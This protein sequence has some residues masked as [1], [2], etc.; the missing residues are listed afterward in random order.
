MIDQLWRRLWPGR[1]PPSEN[2]TLLALAI[3]VGLTTGGGVL[4]FKH[5][6]AFFEEI[7]RQPL[8]HALGDTLGRWAIVPVLALGGLIVG[9]VKQRFIGVERHHGVAGIM[10]AT[11]LAGGRL[12]YGRMPMKALLASFSIGAGASVGPE[13]PSV[14]IGANLG[15]MFGQRLHLSDERVRLLVAAGVAS[16]IAAA[17]RAPIAGVFFALEVIL[18]DLSTSA[19]GVVVLASVVASVLTQALE[20][21]G[22]E[23]GIQNYTLG[24]PQQIPLYVL[25]AVLVAPVSAAYIRLLYWQHDFWHER[26]LPAPVKTMLAGAIVGLIA[27][28]LPEIMGT[29]RETM[30]RL[31]NADSDDFTLTVLAALVVAKM[32]ATTISLGGGFV[33]GMFAPSL[34]VG[35]AFGSLYGHIV[36]SLLP[37]PVAANPAAYAVTGMAATMT[38]VIRAPITTVLLLFEL[39]NDY[40]LIL[41]V[42]LVVAVSLLVVERIAP[43]GIY[44][45]GLARKGIRLSYGRDTDLMQ[46]IMAGDA[47]TPA[48]AYLIQASL[49]AERLEAEFRK[50]NTHGLIVV[51]AEGDLFGIV[52]IQDLARALGNGGLEGLSAGDICTRD[53]LTVTPETP[54][55]DAL[56]LIGQRDVG[57]LPVVDARNPRKVVGMLRRHDILRSYDMALQRKLEALRRGRQVRL[58]TFTRQEVVELRVQP[59]APVANRQIQEIDWPDGTI[60]AAI[61][62]RGETITPHGSTV[63]RDG[64]L[65]TIVTGPEHVE[66]LRQ[67]AAAPEKV[68]R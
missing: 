45:L 1:W 11:A 48:A 57:R 65:L 3:A 18:A 46:T 34:F 66:A 32:V 55:S 64:D 42:M 58:A 43:D 13:D 31:L 29:G 6:F 25:L 26:R 23:L 62:R 38:G 50:R 2:F 51:D 7:Y 54:I 24:G 5:G 67:L 59:H 41:P 33:G 39:T 60:V 30:N 27:A 10:E 14:Q 53:V 28:F 16:G 8:L 40:N 49:P 20:A 4:L 52:T 22:P 68:A 63:V 56:R 36:T 35:A 17:F 12:R 9:A 21:G 19:F 15:S 47:M 44:H 37:T 61:H